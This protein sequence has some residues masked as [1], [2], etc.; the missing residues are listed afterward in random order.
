MYFYGGRGFY[1]KLRARLYERLN[2]LILVWDFKPAWKQVLFTWRFTTA[3]FQNDP[4]FW[5]ACIGI[6]FR[7]LFT[8]N[9]S[10]EIKTDFCQ[11]DRSEMAPAMTF[12]RTCSLSAIFSESAL[13]NFT[14][15]KFCLHEK[16]RFKFH[17][18]QNS[19]PVWVSFHLNLCENK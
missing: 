10:P 13:I 4:I 9:L 12:K 8:W 18:D 16:L 15:G 2:E 3:A 5:W 1:L 6:S 7:V 19:I 11:N 14:S 17:F